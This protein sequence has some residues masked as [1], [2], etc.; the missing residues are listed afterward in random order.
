MVA[1]IEKVEAYERLDEIIAVTDGIMVA[2]GDYGVEAGVAHVPLMQ[3]DTIARATQAGKLVITATQMLESMIHAP[4]PTRAEATDVANAVI[5]GSSAVMLSAETSVG[6]YPGRGGAGD[7]RDRRGRRARA[8]DPRPRAHASRPDTPAAAVMHA[9][10]E[11][12]QE[13]DAVALVVPTA[14]GGAPRACAKYRSQLPIVALAHDRRVADQITLEWGVYRHTMGVAESVDEL[15][16]AALLAARDDAGPA[17][18]RT[19]RAHRRAARPA[20]RARPTSSWCARSPEGRGSA[21]QDGQ[22][23][24]ELDLGL[25]ELGRRVGVAHDADAGVAA[26]PRR[27]RSSAQRSATQN[28]PSSLASVQPTGPGVPAA[29]DALERGDQRARR[30]RAARPRRPASGAAGRRARRR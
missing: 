16:E 3:K 30:P 27:P 28:S 17:D 10:V 20:R 9:A 23:R 2:R 6:S 25:G 4:E 7:G 5:D 14:T 22:Q 15:I 29:V 8:R 18:R 12:A 26:A 11:L 19:R 1:K 13:L 24:A 21:R